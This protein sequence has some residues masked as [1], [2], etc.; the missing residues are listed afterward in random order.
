MTDSASAALVDTQ[1]ARHLTGE[2]LDLPAGWS[3]YAIPVGPSPLGAALSARLRAALGL[4][5]D[6]LEPAEPQVRTLWL[7]T[8]NLYKDDQILNLSRNGR[9]WKPSFGLGRWPDQP[10]PRM[11]R[12]SDMLDLAWGEA[13]RRPYHSVVQLG[14]TGEAMD[15]AWTTMFGLGATIITLVPDGPSAML[16]SIREPLREDIT[17]ESFQDFPFYF[18][19]LSTKTALQASAEQLG[20]WLGPAELYIRESEEDR[21]VLVLSRRP[22]PILQGVLERIGFPTRRQPQPGQAAV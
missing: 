11:T 15:T 3:G 1:A 17:D 10:P 22:V 14:A 20:N 18:P 13:L 16:A 2:E 19:L 5:V 12:V 7:L 8:D 21:A 9:A 4:L 6:R